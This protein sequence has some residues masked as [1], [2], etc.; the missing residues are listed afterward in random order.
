M[1]VKHL[2]KEDYVGV[3]FAVVKLWKVA[4]AEVVFLISLFSPPSFE[5]GYDEF[6]I[7]LPIVYRALYEGLGSVFIKILLKSLLR[8]PWCFEVSGENVEEEA[9]IC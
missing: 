3:V 4:V 6:G 7:V 9:H 1:A 8:L 5:E 2:F